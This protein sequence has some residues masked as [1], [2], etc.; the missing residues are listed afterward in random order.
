MGRATLPNYSVQNDLDGLWEPMK[1]EIV[2]QKCNPLSRKKGILDA[3]SWVRSPRNDSGVTIDLFNPR[4]IC[5]WAANISL[6]ID[7]RA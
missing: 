5:A 1:R 4:R 2:K 7:S 6:S 3:I